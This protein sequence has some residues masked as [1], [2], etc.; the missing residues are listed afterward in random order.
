MRKLYAST[1]NK[2]RSLFFALS[3]LL[4]LMPSI[5]LFGQSGVP[6]TTSGPWTVPA[7]VTSVKVEVWGGGGGGGGAYSGGAGRRRWWR[8]L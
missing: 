2:F 8:N 4:G 6:I 5:H 3:L 7:G 1:F